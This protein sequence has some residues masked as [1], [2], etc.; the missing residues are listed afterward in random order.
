MKGFL[1]SGTTVRINA[2]SMFNC[3]K[4]KHHMENNEHRDFLANG[5][6]LVR[7][8]VRPR[9]CAAESVREFW[10]NSLAHHT[11]RKT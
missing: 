4:I 6:F 3:K 11:G 5:F 2:R 10:L 1:L 8:D 7:R 9:G